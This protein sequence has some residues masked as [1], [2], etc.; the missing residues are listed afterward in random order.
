MT[1]AKWKREQEGEPGQ[2]TQACAVIWARAPKPV[3]ATARPAILLAGLTS[4]V[5]LWLESF[6]RGE[7]ISP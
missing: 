1:E 3:V 5:T 7:G 4:P 2:L 6:L